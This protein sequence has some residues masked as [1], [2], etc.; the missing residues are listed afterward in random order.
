MNHESLPAQGPVDVNVSRLDCYAADGAPVRC[1]KCGSTEQREEVR[2][3]VDVL[4]GQGPV[5]EYE[6]FCAACGEGIG[7]WAYGSFDPGYVRDATANAEIR[8]GEAV[9]LD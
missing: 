8:G 5:C 9:P 3:M 4:Y 1:W 6:V 7:Y 2:S